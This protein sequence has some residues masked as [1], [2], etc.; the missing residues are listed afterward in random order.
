MVQICRQQ[1]RKLHFSEVR[2]FS[3]ER[4]GSASTQ[5]LP[6]LVYD[7]PLTQLTSERKMAHKFHINTCFL[8]PSRPLPKVFYFM[9][10]SKEVNTHKG[11]F[12]IAVPVFCFFLLNKNGFHIA[13]RT[14]D[15]QVGSCLLPLSRKRLTVSL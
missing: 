3:R 14:L 12:L 6:M 11:I 8:K 13:K 4:V 10:L 1:G 5:L 9:S 2:N 7:I 15:L